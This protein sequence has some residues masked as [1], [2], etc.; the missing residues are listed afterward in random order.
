MRLIKSRHIKNFGK[1][2]NSRNNFSSRL[3][4]SN[5]LKKN[6]T[7]HYSNNSILFGTRKALEIFSRFYIDFYMINISKLI[8]LHF[9]I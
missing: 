5:I 3:K 4:H 7:K 9:I 8:N 6:K 1:N 2:K